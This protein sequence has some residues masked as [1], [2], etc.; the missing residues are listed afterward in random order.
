MPTTVYHLKA[1]DSCRKVLKQFTAAKKEVVAIDV[2]ETPLSPETLSRFIEAFGWDKLIN[3]RST[4]WRGLSETQKA[5]AERTALELL[6]AHP[7]LMK[8][9]VIDG[10]NGLTLGTGKDDIA[11]H[12]NGAAERSS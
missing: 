8:R 1:C 2:R 10:P 11:R 7:T 9:P 3:R 12:L 4:T 6:Q 5:D